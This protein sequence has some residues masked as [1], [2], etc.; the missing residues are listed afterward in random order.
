MR[1]N[2]RFTTGD[3]AAVELGNVCW[4]IKGCIWIRAIRALGELHLVWAE[5]CAV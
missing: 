5:W 2:E 4:D 1:R 3:R